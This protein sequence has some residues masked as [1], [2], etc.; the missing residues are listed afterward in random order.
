M[1][2]SIENT[3]D[4]FFAGHTIQFHHFFFL[5]DVIKRGLEFLI[6]VD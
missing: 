6:S 4:I 2:K 1:Y 5:Q 3:L